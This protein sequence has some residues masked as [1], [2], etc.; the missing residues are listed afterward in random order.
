VTAFAPSSF[1][2]GPD[3]TRKPNQGKVPISIFSPQRK[4]ASNFPGRNLIRAGYPTTIRIGKNRFNK[5]D[6]GKKK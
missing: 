4:S 1:N 5:I 2:M 3:F 6:E